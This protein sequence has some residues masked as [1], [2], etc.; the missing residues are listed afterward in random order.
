MASHLGIET[1][2]A[3]YMASTVQTIEVKVC[4]YCGVGYWSVVT[5]ALNARTGGKVGFDLFC[6]VRCTECL[7]LNAQT[8]VFSPVT[9]RK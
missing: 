3:R 5:I 4:D 1:I 6:R 8:W 7:G 2:V 9:K